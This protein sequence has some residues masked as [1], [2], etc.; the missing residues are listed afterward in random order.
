[1]GYFQLLL[2]DMDRMIIKLLRKFVDLEIIPKREAIDTDEEHTV[3]NNI[4]KKLGN[5]GLDGGVALSDLARNEENELSF[6]TAAVMAEELARG[7][8]GIGI[9]SAING[10]ALF[11]AYLS[12]N[13][14]VMDLHSSLVASRVPLFSCFSMTEAQGGCD[15]ENIP[16]T[17]GKSLMTRARIE[18]GRWIINGSK[19]FASNAAV[20][21]LYCV[22]CQTDPAGGEDGIA[23]IYVP[24]DT[25]GLSFGKFEKKAGL[26]ADKN[27]AIYLDNVSV[28][29]EY[30]AAGNGEDARLLSTN[31]AVGRV[32]TAAAAVGCAVGVFDEVLKYTGER[33]AGGKAIREHSL[34]AGMIADMAQG[35]ETARA[36]YLQAAYLLNHPEEGG[37][38]HSAAAL[39]RA[40]IA[41][42]Y[43]TDTAIT[44]T[45][46]AME[47][48]GS[49]G[50]IRDYHVEKY[51]R[52]V[53]ELQLWLGG[54][55]LGQFDI[56]RGYYPYGNG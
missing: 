2:S 42:N 17:H 39:S 54:K 31:L 48:M 41:K 47:L 14:A 21:A 28:P 51:W 5:I 29:L 15:I 11:P 27:A 6:I 38:R 22:V 44:L 23:L 16:L 50:Y 33:K 7:D 46:K 8:I 36:Y 1:M 3:V 37:A 35:I 20:S 45:N 55:Q 10:W 40:S 25:V 12:R 49:Y 26:H 32:V 13:R 19:I 56:A 43:A 18:N 53:K 9:V 34:A 4:L 52:D 30:R 24:G